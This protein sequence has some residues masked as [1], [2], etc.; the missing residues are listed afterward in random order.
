MATNVNLL[1]HAPNVLINAMN[2]VLA[3]LEN[4][5]G[6]ERPL[7]RDYSV[8]QGQVDYDRA[9]ANGVFG[10]AARAGI[11]WGYQ[12]QW[13]PRNWSEAG[14][15]GMYRT[16]YHVLYPDQDVIR[17]A[18][19]WYRVHEEID[20]IPRVIDLELKREQTHGKIAEA[21][22]RMSDVV[23]SRD[24]VRPIIYSR[25]LLVNDWLRT[26][27]TGM[28]NDHF[29]WLAQY[30]TDRVREHEG[31]PTLPE[32]INRDRIILHQ[33]ADKKTQPGEV[34][35]TV[36]FNR[37]C[38]GNVPDMYQFI[39]QNWGGGNIVPEPDE[40]MY[41]VD[42]MGNSFVR[43][44]P[45]VGSVELGYLLKGSRVPVVKEAG[46]FRKISGYVW[47]GHMKKV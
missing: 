25:R 41:L 19:N 12:D 46:R 24:G 10:M 47:D 20:V 39:D 14:R 27:T 33:T 32:R 26:W 37:W 23:F 30:L 16:S 17:Q 35:G 2:W 13:Y 7:W 22:M 9:K 3:P 43:S 15:V 40:V 38:I 42:I 21:T 11:S 31:P 44:G 34:A 29:W 45:S 18:D 5:K 36:D 6:L 28:L 8:Y 4:P 1:D